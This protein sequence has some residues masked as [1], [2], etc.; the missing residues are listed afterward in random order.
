M[1]PTV[2]IIVPIYNAEGFLRR[3]VDSILTQE[4]TDFELILVDDGSTD[5]SASI[6]DEYAASDDRVRVIHK[7][8]SGVSDTR[9]LAISEA[10]GTYLQFLDSDDWITPDATKSFVRAAKEHDCDM[11]ISD[12]YRVVGERLSHKGDIEET[13]VMS[14]E[15]FASHMM[16]NPA[17]FYYGVLWNKLYKR[18]II[19]KYHIRMDTSISWCEDFLFNLEYIR[20]A[21]S[22]YALQVPIY[23][24]VKR[25]GSLVS[26]G[27][28][29]TKTAKMKMSMF[30]Y[31]NNFYKHVF[32]EE[33]YERSRLQIYRFV[34][35][36]A[37][38]DLVLPALMPGSKRL[39]NERTSFSSEALSVDGILA[40]FYRD[41]KLLNYYLETIALKHDLALRDA[42]VL[43]AIDLPHPFT[44]RREIADFTVLPY[45][46]VIFSLQ[47]MSV[48]HLI[49]IEEIKLPKTEKS[50][51]TPRQFRF[52]LLPDS[53]PIIDEIKHALN[54]Y[55]EARFAGFTDEELVQY[56]ALNKKIKENIKK[57][58][59]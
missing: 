24:Y 57:T 7:V 55:K 47:K 30:E 59:S 11:V 2:S 29:L 13:T 51:T 26:Q 46:S 52:T 39:G 23:Y 5:A 48:K 58:L 25:K 19:E 3:C 56:K 50:K 43:C 21:E 35:D 16:E 36:A 53:E 8:N 33:D 14:Q 31:Y 28:S 12:F 32:T 15:E 45:Q 54:E 10:C 40:D 37:N 22:F 6:C 1:N 27:M 42:H 38:D 44:T 49:D 18:E 9:N 20:H 17:D 4:Y 34:F 41:R